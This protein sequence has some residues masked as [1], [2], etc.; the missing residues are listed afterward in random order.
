MSHITASQKEKPV[1]DPSLT[2]QWT[3]PPAQEFA[4]GED[5]TA[6]ARRQRLGLIGAGVALGVWAIGI[7]GTLAYI[8]LTS[9]G[10]SSADLVMSRALVLLAVEVLLAP[11][12]IVTGIVLASVRQTRPFG[13]GFLIGASVGLIVGAGVCFGQAMISSGT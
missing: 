13:V 12:T 6:R 2:P 10:L 1:A 8:E 5:P 3:P 7:V 9:A 4:P 11:I